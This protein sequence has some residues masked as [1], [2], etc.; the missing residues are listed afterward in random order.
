MDSEIRKDPYLWFSHKIAYYK[1]LA[2]RVFGQTYNLSFFSHGARIQV[3]V[4]FE[5]CRRA[6]WHL[7]VFTVSVENDDIAELWPVE[8]AEDG[9]LGS[10]D[11]SNKGIGAR[12]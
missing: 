1:Q 7:S 9:D 6:D 10:T 12:S 3:R 11:W 4:E 8:A 2:L 5:G